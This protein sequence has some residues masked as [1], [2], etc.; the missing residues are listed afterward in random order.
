[1]KAARLSRIVGFFFALGVAGIAPAEAGAIWSCSAG[2]ENGF[3][4]MGWITFTLFCQD[5]SVVSGSSGGQPGSAACTDGSNFISWKWGE[6]NS[7]GLPLPWFEVIQD[8]H[9]SGAFRNH[10]R[11]SIEKLIQQGKFVVHGRLVINDRVIKVERAVL[12]L[13]QSVVSGLPPKTVDQLIQEGV[14]PASKVLYRR[15]YAG[16][17]Y[18]LTLQD[19]ITIA[20]LVTQDSLSLYQYGESPGRTAV[21]ALGWIGIGVLALALTGTGILVLA[22]RSEA[23]EGTRPA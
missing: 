9:K 14:V 7:G 8:N 17:P 20:G 11:D 1:M 6:T 2:K 22:R 5:G 10:L 18:D 21:P 12:K 3:D 15:I 13:P 4:V 19:T 23:H 16:G